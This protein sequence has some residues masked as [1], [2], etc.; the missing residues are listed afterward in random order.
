MARARNLKW[1]DISIKP[2][3]AAYA[4]LP[5]VMEC[6]AYSKAEAA[7]IGRDRVSRECIYDRLDGA[8]KVI[9]TETN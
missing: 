3:R 9:V 6:Q 8:L 5:F 7:K 1:Y 2:V 4:E